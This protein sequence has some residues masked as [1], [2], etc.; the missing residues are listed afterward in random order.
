MTMYW[1]NQSI[2]LL[3]WKLSWRMIRPMFWEREK[4]RRRRRQTSSIRRKCNEKYSNEVD[5]I[6]CNLSIM[7]EWPAVNWTTQKKNN[8]KQ[9][10]TLEENTRLACYLTTWWR[11]NFWSCST[12][13]RNEE[14]EMYRYK[15]ITICS[16]CDIRTIFVTA[17]MLQFCR[18]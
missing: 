3:V 10:A 4:R 17:G 18:K 8:W 15:N 1:R 14:V 5:K 16:F 9:S 7:T 12:I 11:R 2:R 13:N 6:W